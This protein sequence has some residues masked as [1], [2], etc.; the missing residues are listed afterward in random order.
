VCTELFSDQSAVIFPNII[1]R[2]DV[3]TEGEKCCLER[4]T[5]PC[6]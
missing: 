4:C 2:G 6:K 5:C 3:C 1:S